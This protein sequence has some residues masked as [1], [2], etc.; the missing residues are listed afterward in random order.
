MSIFQTDHA[1]RLDSGTGIGVCEFEEGDR[2]EERGGRHRLR[3]E[4]GRPFSLYILSA[5]Y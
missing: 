3:V 5:F 4:E 1:H 2:D